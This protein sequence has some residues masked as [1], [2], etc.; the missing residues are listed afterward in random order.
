[1]LVVVGRYPRQDYGCQVIYYCINE[2]HYLPQV[3]SLNTTPASSMTVALL[4]MTMN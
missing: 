2:H 4:L 1:M 3:G